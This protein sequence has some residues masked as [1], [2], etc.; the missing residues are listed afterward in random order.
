MI[1]CTIDSGL[2]GAGSDDDLG[3]TE[4]QQ[5]PTVSAT[6]VPGRRRRATDAADESSRVVET[7]SIE[8]DAAG[9]SSSRL[10]ASSADSSSRFHGRRR[11]GREGS[12]ARESDEGDDEVPGVGEVLHGG[13]A[14]F[15]RYNIILRKGP[16]SQFQNQQP[17]RTI[18]REVFM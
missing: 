17:F 13:H 4:A 7:A 3:W 11:Q 16:F 10:G 18:I 14:A 1:L 8:R 6:A 2:D 15:Y 12:S 9:L 5:P